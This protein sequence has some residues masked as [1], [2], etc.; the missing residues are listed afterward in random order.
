VFSLLCSVHLLLMEPWYNELWLLFSVIVVL[1]NCDTVIFFF[2]A[3][4]ATR[5]WVC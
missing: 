1:L 4:T 2:N 3:I 5:F